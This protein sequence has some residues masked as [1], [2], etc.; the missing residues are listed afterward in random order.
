MSNVQ[1]LTFTQDFLQYSNLSF[2]PLLTTI[3]SA[4][5]IHF[6]AIRSVKMQQWPSL[7]LSFSFTHS[8]K[9]IFLF[10]W[11]YYTHEEWIDSHAPRGVE[12]EREYFRLRLSHATKHHLN[13]MKEH[14]PT[15]FT[16]FFFFHFLLISFFIFTFAPPY[17]VTT[18]L[19]GAMVHYYLTDPA[20]TRILAASFSINGI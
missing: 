14:Y 10:L 20:A 16:I 11:P 5:P 18:H 4:R 6:A 8:Q 7:S 17:F 9:R 3:T 19:S 1:L 12:R 2:S 15:S 13:F